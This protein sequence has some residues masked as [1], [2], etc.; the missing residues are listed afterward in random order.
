MS[1]LFNLHG[2][3]ALITG[4]GQGVGRETALRFAEHGA[5]GVIVNDFVRERAEAVAEEI[6]AAGGNARAFQ[7]DVTDG[8]SVA[9]M[10][11]FAVQEFGGL[12]ILVNN[13][14]N[15]GPSD[16]IGALT[17]FWETDRNEWD[18]WLGTNL[19]G[20]LHTCKAAIPLI[21]KS[22]GGRLITVISEAGRSGEPHLAVYSGAKAGAAGF[23]R[24]IARA[25]A[26]HNIT[27]N[28]VALGTIETPGVASL[29]AD[30]ATNERVKKLYPLR[31]F[32][33][34]ADAAAA[35]LFLAGPSGRWITG[36]TYPVNGGY[37][38]NQ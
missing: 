20:V 25:V 37:T 28:N 24:G 1:D 34:P 19:Y 33:Q 22:G 18:R 27:A 8:E 35:I 3:V 32:G 29:L 36:Q 6:R 26:R 11:A 13:A 15:A 23:T 38:F 14:G 31:S 5:E 21:I 4:A 9:A 16:D 7:A 12:N 2:Q 30:E 17:A 10:M